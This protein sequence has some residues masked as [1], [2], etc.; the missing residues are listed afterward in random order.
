MLPCSTWSSV[1]HAVLACVQVTS[2]LLLLLLLLLGQQ[3]S[4]LWCQQQY[5][6]PLSQERVWCLLLE[7]SPC[8]VSD[9]CVLW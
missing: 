2:L 7:L 9:G 5:R 3:L 4:Q 8:K 6:R 1:C